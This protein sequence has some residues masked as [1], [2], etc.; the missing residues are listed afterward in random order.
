MSCF[1]SDDDDQLLPG[2]YLKAESVDSALGGSMTSALSVE[3]Q[4][5]STPIRYA[6]ER[7]RELAKIIDG[8]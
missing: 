2:D 5:R 3:P 4:A 7:E 1:V 8:E 6:S